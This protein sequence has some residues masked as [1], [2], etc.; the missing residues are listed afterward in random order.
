M[1]VALTFLLI[2]ALSGC[3]EGPN[4]HLGGELVEFQS[5]VWAYGSSGTTMSL[6]LSS[7]EDHCADVAEHTAWLEAHPDPTTEDRIAHSEERGEDDLWRATVTWWDVEFG[8]EAP[9]ERREL[10]ENGILPSGDT[11][12][13]LWHDIRARDQEWFEGQ[14]ENTGDYITF[15]GRADDAWVEAPSHDPDGILVANGEA[16]FG[17]A[18]SPQGGDPGRIFF[19]VEATHC[20]AMEADRR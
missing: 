15:W 2:F 14:M 4:G 20:A 12:L 18:D 17:E 7:R 9:S 10:R 16:T 3:V 19:D 5:A 8:S 11:T 1:R 6:M 13:S